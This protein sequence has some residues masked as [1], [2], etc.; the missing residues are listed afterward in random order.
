MEVRH[1]KL[2]HV[3]GRRPAK[4]SGYTIVP[5]DVELNGNSFSPSFPLRG[6]PSTLIPPIL[7]LPIEKHYD[8]SWVRGRLP[9]AFGISPKPSE[10][11]K[12][13]LGTGFVAV[14]DGQEQAV[15]FECS[16]YYGRTSLMFSYEETD[17]D[18][19]S[20]VAN[21]FWLI[22][23]AEPEKLED[24]EATVL[25]LGAPVT[26]RFGCRD[27]EPFYEETKS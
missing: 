18:L 14:P 7:R 26:M 16:D 6:M 13:L 21:A 11:E 15:A 3:Y 4:Q 19:K 9:H 24:F 1:A 22:L 17:E 20:Q 23:L 8:V 10:M 5:A 12:T 2:L 25:H 27:G